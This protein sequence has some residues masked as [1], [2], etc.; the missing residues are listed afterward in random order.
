VVAGGV[1]KLYRWYAGRRLSWVGPFHV[2]FDSCYT[3]VNVWRPSM[4]C[5]VDFGRLCLGSGKYIC[6]LYQRFILSCESI[7]DGSMSTSGNKCN[8]KDIT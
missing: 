7:Q 3:P 6:I 8:I 5:G 4:L 1:L 2:W